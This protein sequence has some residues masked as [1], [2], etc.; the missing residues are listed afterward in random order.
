MK[1]YLS[2]FRL[3][4]VTGLQYR[5]A[6]LG[7]VVT[8]FAWGILKILV[9]SAFF[10]SNS[11]EL[12][13]TLEQTASYIW[14]Q[15]SFL[16]FF[17]AWYVD[18]DIFDTIV[19]GD[20]AYELCRPVDIYNMWFTKNIANR[21]SRALLR[22]IPILCLVIFIPAPYGIL[23][24]HS[25]ESFLLFAVS[26]LLG[27]MVMTAFTSLIYVITFY[28]ISPAG[29]RILFVSVVEFFTGGI[30]PLPFFPDSVR[31]FFELLP[32]G[33]MQDTPLRIY[34]GN[35]AGSEIIVRMAL[36][37]GWIVALVVLGKLLCRHALKRVSLQGG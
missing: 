20:V 12:P 29:V 25:A 21:M 32:F 31:G 35:M 11:G 24:P 5:A 10:A 36:Q 37:A 30:I 18:N 28:T 16:A 34:S 23:A 17:A 14:L 15:Q 6:A 2:F 4:F 13:M 9:Y 19:N 33:S 7:G 1:K 8:Q 22:S 3:R 26:M 27:L